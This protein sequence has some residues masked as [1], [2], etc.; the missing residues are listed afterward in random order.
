MNLLPEGGRIAV[1]GGQAAFDVF[2]KLGFSAFHFSRAQGVILPGGRGLF[3]VCESGISA[4]AVLAAAGLK[5]EETQVIDAAARVT[6]TVWRTT[7][8]IYCRTAETK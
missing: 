1:P 2:L 5:P 6:L 7:N 8:L 4:E 3:S